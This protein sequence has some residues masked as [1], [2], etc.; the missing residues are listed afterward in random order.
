MPVT[1]SSGVTI[2]SL[3]Y[4]YPIRFGCR[5]VSFNIN[6]HVSN[7]MTR[8]LYLLSFGYCFCISFFLF[9]YRL[10]YKFTYLLASSFNSAAVV[11]DAIF[12]KNGG[13]VVGVKKI[14]RKH[15]ASR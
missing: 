9:L 10:V 12:R 13:I 8:W 5:L 14:K 4:V 15:V 11:E 6:H 2:I 7:K 3:A 1:K